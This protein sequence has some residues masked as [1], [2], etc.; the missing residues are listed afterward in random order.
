[1]M[2]VAEFLESVD[3][4]ALGLDNTDNVLR[5]VSLFRL[6]DSDMKTEILSFLVPLI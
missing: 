3:M 4:V 1:M 2:A 5:S 6:P